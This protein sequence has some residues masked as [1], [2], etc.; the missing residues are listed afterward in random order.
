VSAS[1][2]EIGKDEPAGLGERENLRYAVHLAERG[3]V[4]LVP[5]YP[6]FGEYDY[7]FKKSGLQER[8]MKAIWNNMRRSTCCVRCRR[9]T[10]SASAASVIRSAATTDVT[11]AFDVRIKAAVS[12]CGFTSFPK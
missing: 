5:D 6:S 4:T 2:G 7:D 12:N 8:S 3:Y 10:R 11:A 1:D 9:W